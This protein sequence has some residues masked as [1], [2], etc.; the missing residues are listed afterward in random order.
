MIGP[1]ELGQRYRHVDGNIAVLTRISAVSYGA[2]TY[3]VAYCMENRLDKEIG[4]VWGD[5]PWA[6]H[7]NQMQGTRPD[8]LEFLSGSAYQPVQFDLFD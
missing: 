3:A 2:S 4:L 5:G 1:L 6:G 7:R 8:L